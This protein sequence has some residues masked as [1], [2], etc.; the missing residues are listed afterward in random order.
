MSAGQA[1]TV[2]MSY[3]V[4]QTHQNAPINFRGILFFERWK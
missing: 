1:K 3:L 4:G 2:N